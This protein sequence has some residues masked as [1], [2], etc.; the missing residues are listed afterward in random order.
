MGDEEGF[1]IHI[2]SQQSLQLVTCGL[3][4]V[5]QN[6]RHMGNMFPIVSFICVTFYTKLQIMYLQNAY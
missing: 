1:Q 2:Q 5:L 3:G 4:F 6:S